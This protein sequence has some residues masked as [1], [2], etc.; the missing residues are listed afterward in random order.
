MPEKIKILLEEYHLT[1]GTLAQ[2]INVPA[3]TISH[4]LSGRNKISLEVVRKLAIRFPKVN[5]Q[6]LMDLSDEMFESPRISEN[7]EVIAEMK[8]NSDKIEEPKILTG[9]K[10]TTSENAVVQEV[11]VTP[12]TQGQVSKVIIVYSNGT[13]ESLDPK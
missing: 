6:W 10:N 8:A 13:F 1:A 11:T 7:L 3:A 2:Q 12:R 4:I 5:I 9:A